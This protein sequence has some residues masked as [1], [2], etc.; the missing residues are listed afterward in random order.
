MGES[1]GL[2]GAPQWFLA[3]HIYRS[4][5]EYQ[6]FHIDWFYLLT[7]IYEFQAIFQNVFFGVH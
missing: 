4:G 6:C 2:S 5:L 7:N 1:L 3:L